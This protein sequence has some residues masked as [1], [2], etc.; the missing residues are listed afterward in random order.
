MGRLTADPKSSQTPNG[1][2]VATFSLAVSRQ[3]QKDIA[4]FINIVAWRHIADFVSKYFIKGQQ[5]IVEGSIQTRKYEDKQGNKRIAFEV[6]A[7][8]VF[9]AGGK[10][11]DIDS[12]EG[13]TPPPAPKEK[14]EPTQQNTAD[15][16][17]LPLPN[18]ELPININEF[19]DI[20]DDDDMYF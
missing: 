4:D 2:S 15:N 3:H 1:I 8:H 7:E 18:E 5:V 12:L 11:N 9:F 20:E 6:V 13:L 10:K 17:S 14:I 19:E 16:S